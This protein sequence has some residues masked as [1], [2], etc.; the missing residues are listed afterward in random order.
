M[1]YLL[2]NAQ[3]YRDHTFTLGDLAIIDGKIAAA[4]ASDSHIIDCSGRYIF[5]GLIY[6]HVHFREPGYTQKETIRTGSM[7]AASA[8]AAMGS[9]IR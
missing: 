3:I 1:N 4:P 2:T 8:R 5:P 9:I 7:A 6:V